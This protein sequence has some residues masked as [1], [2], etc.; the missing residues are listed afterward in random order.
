MEKTIKKFD[1]IKIQ[2]QKCQRHK[3]TI[4]IKIVDND[5]IVVSNKVP[6]GEKRILS[7]LFATEMLKKQSLYVYFYRK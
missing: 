6:C 2:K 7:T 1:D 4:S 3:T 5:K